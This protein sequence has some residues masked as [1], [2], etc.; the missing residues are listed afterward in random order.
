M[1]GRGGDLMH[2]MEKEPGSLGGG[3][4]CMLIALSFLENS[5]RDLELVLVEKY[6][7][8]ES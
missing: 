5:R 6:A 4:R 2:A 7:E 8:S 1:Y 3:S